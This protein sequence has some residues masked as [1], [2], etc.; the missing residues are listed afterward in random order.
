MTASPGRIA[1]VVSGGRISGLGHVQRCTALASA[2]TI[3]G[4]TCMFVVEGDDSAA[5]EA[6][7]AGFG[8]KLAEQTDI[9]DEVRRTAAQVV[10]VD[11]YQLHDAQ[12]RSLAKVCPRIVVIDDLADRQLPVS[13]VV[14]GAV[15][16]RRELYGDSGVARYLLG[17]AYVLL[18]PEFAEPVRRSERP[19][20]ER[21]LVT[22]GGSDARN[23]TPRLVDWVIEELPDAAV[24]VVVGPFFTNPS[25]VSDNAGRV[26]RRLSLVRNPRQIREFMLAADIAVCAGGQTTYELAATGTPALGIQL[27]PNQRFNLEGLSKAGTLRWVGEV[28][29]PELAVALR[30]A[31]RDLANRPL[32]RAAMTSAGTR[33]V[34]GHGCQR[35]AEA[36]AEMT[37]A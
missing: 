24:D 18:R 33:A 16:A 14:N 28:N 25:P 30:T 8:A 29:D 36:I 1:F 27:A 17:P 13:I 20:V 4:F 3:H 23:I 22:V 19:Q 35:V 15:G 31:L 11:S 26:G 21:V 6:R 5:T 7:A 32:D 37:A 9:C 34:D 10:V 2:L 12:L